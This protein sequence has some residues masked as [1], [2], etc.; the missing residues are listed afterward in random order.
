MAIA[1]TWKGEEKTG[2]GNYASA[3]T[4]LHQ[5]LHKLIRDENTTKSY[6]Q[7][8][9][10][11][12]ERRCDT[13]VPLHYSKHDYELVNSKN[14]EELRMVLECDATH[15]GPQAL[16]CLTKVLTQQQFPKGYYFG[17]GKE[18]VAVSADLEE[19]FLHSMVPKT[20]RWAL[21]LPWWLCR[22]L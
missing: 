6:A 12:I 8:V 16:T 9:E 4:R 14:P 11:T 17:F 1:L 19:M 21:Q 10:R 20:D 7:S 18:Q 3:L 22:D 13:A 15:C 2:S 5:F